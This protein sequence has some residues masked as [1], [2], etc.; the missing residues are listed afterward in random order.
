MLSPN[1]SLTT[2]SRQHKLQ[3][4]FTVLLLVSMAC[5]LPSF[6]QKA[7]EE[8]VQ[9]GQ[10]GEPQPGTTSEPGATPTAQPSPTLPPEPLPPALVE[11]SPL[12]G[13]TLPLQGEITLYFNQPM[14]RASVE[15]ALRLPSKQ[16]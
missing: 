15:A 12:P 5:S 2:T 3:I 6:G 4:F 7:T 14:Q 13:S 11:A 1:G 10:A 8:P 9:P 16:P